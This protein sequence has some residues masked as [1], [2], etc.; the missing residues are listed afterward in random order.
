[1]VWNMRPKILVSLAVCALALTACSSAP[2]PAEPTPNESKAEV[3]SAPVGEGKVSAR[4]ETQGETPEKEFLEA[5]RVAVEPHEDYFADLDEKIKSEKY[6]LKVGNE[7]CADFESGDL[8]VA[9]NTGDPLEDEYQGIIMRAAIPT[10]C[11]PS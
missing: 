7:K 8:Q 5:V 6:W 9:S 3:Q 1:M 4:V 10:L 2:A 11:P